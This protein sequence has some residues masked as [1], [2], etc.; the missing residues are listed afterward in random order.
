[1][2]QVTTRDN[3]YARLQLLAGANFPVVQEGTL[4]TVATAAGETLVQGALE[5]LSGQ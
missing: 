5:E 2:A 4:V 1:V 3:G